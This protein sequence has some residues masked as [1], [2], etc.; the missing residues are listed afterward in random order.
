MRRSRYAGELMS[1]SYCTGC[2]S[3]PSWLGVKTKL[4]APPAAVTYGFLFALLGGNPPAGTPTIASSGV[5]RSDDVPAA[6]PTCGS[7]A[8]ALVA[9]S[10]SVSVAPLT[11]DPPPA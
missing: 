11:G 9:K 7:E 3:E 2:R 1:S 8:I 5:R 6:D 4:Y 10:R